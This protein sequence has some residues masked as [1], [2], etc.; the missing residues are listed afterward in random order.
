VL[1]NVGKVLSK[2]RLVNLYLVPNNIAALLPASDSQ[3]QT[4]INSIDT[5]RGYLEGFPTVQTIGNNKYQISQS[6]SYNKWSA[7]AN[8]LYD[9]VA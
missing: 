6:W 1:D 9:L 7:G 5:F 3:V 8:G 4:D 2:D